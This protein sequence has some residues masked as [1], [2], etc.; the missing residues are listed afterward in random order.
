MRA[1]A[2]CGAPSSAAHVMKYT[3]KCVTGADVKDGENVAG[4]DEVVIILQHL[5]SNSYN[6]KNIS[7]LFD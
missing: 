3:Y 4:F 1:A 7:Y 6:T 2:P 5:D